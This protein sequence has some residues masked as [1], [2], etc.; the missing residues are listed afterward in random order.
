MHGGVPDG[1]DSHRFGADPNRTHPAVIREMQRWWDAAQRDD[2]NH[3]E[4][5]DEREYTVFYQRM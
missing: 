5:L 4:K 1:G 2:S 3:D